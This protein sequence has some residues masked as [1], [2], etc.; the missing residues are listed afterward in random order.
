MAD[1]TS[2][3]PLGIIRNL[4][5][6]IGGYPFEISAVVLQLDALGVYP[7][8]LGWPWLRMANI[9]HNWQHNIINF[10][11]GQTKFRVP[12]RERIM[13]NKETTPLYAEGVRLDR[14]VDEE[15]DRY[16]EENPKLVPLFEINVIEVV[17]PYVLRKTT[18]I[19]EDLWEPDPEVVVELRHAQEA[20][21]G[22][23]EISRCVKG[24]ILE[25]VNLGT[26]EDPRP[27]SIAK[28]LKLDDKAAMVALMKD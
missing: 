7:L 23:M 10:R 8:Q 16:L 14:L 6:I 9:K 21:E 27:I 19:D 18:S 3:R 20:F 28:E 22:G 11:R 26:V 25:E 2:V 17:S 4:E 12:T 5:I 15:V 1:A 24:S 13:T